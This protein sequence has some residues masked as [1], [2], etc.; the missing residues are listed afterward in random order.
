MT[1]PND[2]PIA[3][4]PRSRPEMYDVLA[5]AVVDAGGRLGGLADA[6]AL[7]WADP[8][9]A[10]DFPGIIAQ[11]PHVSWIQLPYAGINPFVE[12]LDAD[13]IWTCGK[14]T[15]ARPVAEYA[16]GAILAGLRGFP[17]YARASTWGAPIGHN[18]DAAV[19]TIIG[20]GGIAGE[21]LA[22]LEPFSCETRVV[23]RTP[24][25]MAGADLVVGTDELPTACAGADVVVVAAALTPETTGI[26]DETVLAA[27]AD[28]GWVVNVGRG[29]HVVTADLLSALRTG[30]IGGAFLDVHDTE[31]LPD[32]SEL[33]NEPNVVITPHIGNTPAMGLTLL[34][35]TV[36][37]NVGRWLRGDELVSLVDVE[38]GY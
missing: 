14:G 25:P 1:N 17:T 6:G 33:W 3:V 32:D 27:M 20:G 35:T 7:I 12:H 5:R 21:L 19:V 28:H 8:K 18:L 31:P 34:A 4:A 38:A 30:G 23:R 15:Y 13:H 24:R 11:A 16:L 9:A 36:T 26:V 37:E 2:R 22:L 10:A 29:P